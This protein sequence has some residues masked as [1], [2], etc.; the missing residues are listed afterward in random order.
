MVSAAASASAWRPA[1]GEYARPAIGEIGGRKARRKRQRRHRVVLQRRELLVNA[2]GRLVVGALPADR[3]QE[4]QLPERL[5]EFLPRCSSSSARCSRAGAAGVGHVDMRIGAV[6]DQRVRMLHHFGR[7]IGVQIE[8]DHQ[9][10]I[11]ADH[12]AH[13]REDF[14][15]AIVEMFRHHRAVQVEID[16]V[17]RAGRPRCRR[18]SPWRCAQRHP[19]SHAPR[20]G[21][22]TRWSG[23]APSHWLRPPR[24]TRRARH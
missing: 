6:G 10:Q 20:G 8:A 4:R 12:L 18:S 1:I 15:F 9:R 19:W 5:C 16:G 13:A 24:R 21:G 23:P 11:L 17:E 2:F 3:D 14:A 22:R 7:H